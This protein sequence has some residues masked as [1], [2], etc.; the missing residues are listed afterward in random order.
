LLEA[1]CA[2]A[3][4]GYNVALMRWVLCF[5]LFCALVGLYVVWDRRNE[6]P[7]AGD[8]LTELRR[9]DIVRGVIAVGRVE[10]RTRVE[11]KSKANG[12]LRRLYVDVAE[13]VRAGQ[14]IAELDREILEARVA[15]SEGRL[16][17]ARAGL[18]SSEAEVQRLEV[19]RSDPELVYAE[20]NWT[21]SRDLHQGGLASDDELD[22]ARDRFEKSQY[23]LRLLGAQIEVAKADLDVARGRLKEVEAQAELARQELQE[24][25][26]TSPIDGLV[27]HRY[28]EEGD[29]V[30][31]IRVAGGNATVVMT[32][33]D[34]RELY[35]DGEVDEVDV[36]K[37]ISRQKIRP[38]LSARVSI[39]SFK[40][41]IFHG[42]VTRV[43]PLGLED[44]NGIVTFEVR[45]VLDNPEQLLLA[46][47]TANSQIVLEEKKDVL[48]LSQA[49]L[50][51]EREQRFALVYDQD[52]GRAR[53]QEVRTGI[54]DG[55]QVEIESGL[56]A[57]QKVVIP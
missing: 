43:A 39:E 29:S 42:R 5:V 20:R 7:I 9:G 49:A 14:V 37:I 2:A 8:R 55:S 46:N 45:I 1:L 15:E 19:E 54:T 36:G 27:L 28:L 57:G 32:L 35:V 34:L 40:D 18:K 53:R 21:R 44:Q 48:I 56:D 24:T 10:P 33:G 25:S 52:T 50:I 47:M 26:I 38:D 6:A 51:T 12:I 13:P 22:T 11:V 41:R 30:S 31:S 16:L 3:L 17:Q 4:R 23:R